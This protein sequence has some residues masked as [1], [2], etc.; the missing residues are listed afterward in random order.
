MRIWIALALMGLAACA[1]KVSSGPQDYVE[2]T[3]GSG[4]AGPVT[5]RIYATDRIVRTTEGRG[6]RSVEYRA[7]LP[8]AYDRARG[9]IAARL[10]A[11]ARRA[12]D[13]VCPDYGTDAVA[14]SIPVRGVTGVSVRCPDAGVSALIS[15]TLA[16]SQPGG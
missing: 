6:G 16:A 7:G 11:V 10:P 1:P 2:L 8:G 13:Q 9:V 12:T 15:A 4:F 14:V 5:T 3:V